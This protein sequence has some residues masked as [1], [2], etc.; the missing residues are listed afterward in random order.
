MRDR[1]RVDH[2]ERGVEIADAA[3]GLHADVR[4]NRSTHDAHIL[5]RR[6]ARAEPRR[7]LHVVRARLDREDAAAL[8]RRGVQVPG[9]ENDLHDR[10]AFRCLGHGAHHRSDVVVHEA[11]VALEQRREVEDH[12]HLVA[13]ELH[14]MRGLLGLRLGVRIAEREAA[15]RADPR[16]GA[17]EP[18]RRER[19]RGTAT[20]TAP[21][22]PDARTTPSTRRPSDSPPWA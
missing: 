22:I 2:R 19:R 17:R 9:L 21:R 4:P 11:I 10:R 16:I 13:A 15:D 18:L 8:D 6:A 3:G 1:T 14:E 5:D 20:R 7:S 12:V